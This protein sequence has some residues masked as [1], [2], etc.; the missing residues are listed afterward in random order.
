MGRKPSGPK[1]IS[2]R[3]HVLAPEQG[4]FFHHVFDAFHQVLTIKIP[5]S[6]RRYFQNTP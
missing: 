5:P 3:W 6:N 2:K 4:P 1:N